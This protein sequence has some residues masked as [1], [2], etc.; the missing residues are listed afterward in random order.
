M[1]TS[2]TS[3]LPNAPLVDIS[4]LPMEDTCITLVEVPSIPLLVSLVAPSPQPLKTMSNAE[5]LIPLT[6]IDEERKD[7]NPSRGRGRRCGKRHGRRENGRVQVSPTK[8]MVG[9]HGRLIRKRKTHSCSTHWGC[10]YI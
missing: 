4:P 7:D 10:Y 8:P 1:R 9:H 2:H 3:N 5:E 6:N